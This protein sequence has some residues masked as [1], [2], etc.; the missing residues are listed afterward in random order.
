MT[1]V[2][3][4]LRPIPQSSVRRRLARAGL[5]GAAVV[6]LALAAAG[7]AAA[8]DGP[9]FAGPDDAT[10][11]PGV[12]TRTGPEGAQ[13]TA[14]FVFTDGAEVYLGQAAHCAGTGGSTEVDGCTAESL[15][16]GTPVEI[17]GAERPG[18]LTYSSWLSMQEAGGADPDTCRF[19]DF[20]L[21]R[22]DPADVARTNPTM[23]FYG[24]PTGV[25]ADGTRAGEIV[26]GYGNSELRQGVA[27]LR[28]KTGTSLGTTGGGRSHTVTTVLPGIPGDS[29]SGYLSA[30]GAALGVLST[31]NLAP[32]PGTNGVSDLRSAIDYADGP[33]GFGGSLRLVAGEKPFDPNVVPVDLGG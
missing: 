33:G 19:N 20:A 3:E 32:A 16:L 6:A 18:A 30:D 13:R 25:D 10:V 1:A 5:A 22:I 9:G 21:V 12:M 11:T 15:P 29:G 8:Q 26:F 2:P 24:G 17:E 7:T 27:A 4:N 14:N 23:P 28:P 31:L